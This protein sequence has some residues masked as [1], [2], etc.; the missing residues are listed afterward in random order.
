MRCAMF[1]AQ[2]TTLWDL[3]TNCFASWNMNIPVNTKEYFVLTEFWAT[4]YTEI[5][6]HPYLSFNLLPL[7]SLTFLAS[8]EAFLHCELNA[9]Y[10]VYRKYSYPCK[11]YRCL[12]GQWQNFSTRCHFST[13]HV[14]S[15][16]RPRRFAGY[17]TKRLAT[18][19]RW[20]SEGQVARWPAP[21]ISAG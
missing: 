3:S 6:V 4:L 1:S 12:C 21:L 19:V 20:A 14:D 8:V 13:P 2:L 18:N 7:E 5:L 10:R 17:W 11:K 16:R 9:R 15:T